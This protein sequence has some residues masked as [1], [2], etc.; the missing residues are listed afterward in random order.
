M[1]YITFVFIY[2]RIYWSI[3]SDN[4]LSEITN[5]MTEAR[6]IELLRNMKIHTDKS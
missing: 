5:N 6:N 2:R 3:K 1:F 4:F